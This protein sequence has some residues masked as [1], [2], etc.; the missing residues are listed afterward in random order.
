MS[1]G[2]CLC[3]DYKFSFPAEP[4]AYVSC[5]CIPCRKASGGMNSLNWI[6][7]ADS[8][9]VTSS[10]G[11]RSWSRKGDSGKNLTYV[12]CETCGT[13]VHVDAE[14]MGPNR[15]L[16]IGTFDDQSFLEKIGAP[17]LQIYMKNCASW[18]LPYTNA[19]S[20]QES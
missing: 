14:A 6:V 16:K 9:K 7:P 13:V 4:V 8:I 1:T 20:K 5:H 18:E 3:G 12:S 10:S 2:S 17:K 11:T 15:I 19:A